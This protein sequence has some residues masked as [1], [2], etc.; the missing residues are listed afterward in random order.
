MTEVGEAKE[1]LNQVEA[2][3]SAEQT[4]SAWEKTVEAGEPVLI[5]PHVIWEKACQSL[6]GLSPP[7]AGDGGL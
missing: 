6:Q 3:V 1:R 4:R 7:G 2:A 5:R